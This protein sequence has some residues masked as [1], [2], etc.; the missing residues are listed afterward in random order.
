[1]SVL[2]ELL[3]DIL[4]FT[5]PGFIVYL[6][7]RNMLQQHF[8][9]QRQMQAARMRE[10][11]KST[12]LQLRLQA[13]ERLTLFCQRIHIPNLLLR[14]SNDNMTVRDLRTALLLAIQQEFDHNI[15][16]QVYVSDQLW[17][18]IQLARNQEVGIIDQV[19]ENFDAAEP[20][21]VYKRA[22]LE[23]LSS[24]EQDPIEKALL[25]VKR[26]AGTLF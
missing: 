21:R 4:K 3:L 16:Q 2:T 11:G 19:A 13:Y 26:E 6:V 7:V 17:Q 20:G 1:M 10:E 23:Y 24:Q 12:T 8:Q 14:L 15:T 5:V 18:I 9:H 22:L 25:A